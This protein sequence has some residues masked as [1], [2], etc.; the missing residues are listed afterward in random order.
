[1]GQDNNKCT[2]FNTTE[3]TVT[4]N[5]EKIKKMTQIEIIPIEKAV[6]LNNQ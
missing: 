5:F 2:C 1:M 3:D 6:S 4:A